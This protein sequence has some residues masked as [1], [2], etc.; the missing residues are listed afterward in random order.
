MTRQIKFTR[1]EG[2]LRGIFKQS[3]AE[4][5]RYLRNDP[6]M[7]HWV[8]VDQPELMAHALECLGPDLQEQDL[9]ATVKNMPYLFLLFRRGKVETKNMHVE[10]LIAF[11]ASLG[12]AGL[13]N[14]MRQVSD[15][16]ALPT[17]FDLDPDTWVPHVFIISG[18][19]DLNY[20]HN[21]GEQDPNI[22]F[23]GNEGRLF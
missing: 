4:F 17:M 9:A 16:E 3:V 15:L 19:V 7:Y 23:F 11:L 21:E 2:S 5:E 18:K 13:F 20:Y 8:C 22:S 10:S 12:Q 6:K 1:M 14:V